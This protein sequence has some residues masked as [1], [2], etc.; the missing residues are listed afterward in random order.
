MLFSNGTINDIKTK[1]LERIANV[2]ERYFAVVGD[3]GLL[4]TKHPLHATEDIL[5]LKNV[6]GEE[7]PSATTYFDYV[8]K[9]LIKDRRVFTNWKV[10]PTK[11]LWFHKPTLNAMKKSSHWITNYITERRGI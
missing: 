10:I 9:C 8:K 4:L 7:I 11:R 3:N 6:E 1:S 2:K 5:C